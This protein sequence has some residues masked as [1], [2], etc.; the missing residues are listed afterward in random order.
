MLDSLLEID[1]QLLVFLNNLGNEHWDTFW[2]SVTRQF[3]WIPLFV[4]LIFLVI[5]SFG[6]KQG[7]IIV[8]AMVVLVVFSDQITNLVKDYFQR[9]RPNNDPS[10]RSSLRHF[11][12]P[13]SYSFISGHATTSTFFTV[14]T[15]LI[16]RKKYR[17]IYFLI[18]FPLLFS[19]SRIYIGVHFP[20]DILVGLVVGTF[21][22]IFYHSFFRKV[23]ERLVG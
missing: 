14:F 17:Y 4:F 11:Y 15:I 20:L 10:I 2:M 23:Y 8:L 1:A 9:L 7:S 13:Q 5:K 22:A 6:W 12:S 3:N 19:Y 21:F 18:I 16:L